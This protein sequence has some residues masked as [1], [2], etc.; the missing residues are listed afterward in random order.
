MVRSHQVLI[1]RYVYLETVIISETIVKTMSFTT[2][3]AQRRG[4]KSAAQGTSFNHVSQ[5]PY[6]EADLIR[7]PAG[8]FRATTKR[9]RISSIGE[10]G[11]TGLVIHGSHDIDPMEGTDP[12]GAT[13]PI[14]GDTLANPDFPVSYNGRGTLKF[15]S[16]IRIAS[17]DGP[18]NVNGEVYSSSGLLGSAVDVALWTVTVGGTGAGI[19]FTVDAANTWAT[20]AIAA[21][22]VTIHLHYTWTSKNGLTDG[23]AIFIKGLPLALET[24]VHKVVIHTTG[25]IATQLGSYFIADGAVDATELQIKSADSATGVETNVTG[26]QTDDT[27]GTISCVLSYHGVVV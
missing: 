25:I 8:Q 19:D 18:L 11:A 7:Q 23:T 17:I 3:R 26:L 12:D 1:N 5:T 10:D 14:S 16:P 6:P 21:D 9:R 13:P 15:V 24:Q 20:Y 27:G 4:T 2:G 22:H